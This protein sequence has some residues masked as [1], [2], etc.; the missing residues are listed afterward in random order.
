MIWDDAFNTGIA[1]WTG[2]GMTPTND[3]S[4]S[5]KIGHYLADVTSR[6]HY[7]PFGMQMP[8][9]DNLIAAA[10]YRY[11]FQG[12]EMDNEIKGV[13]NSYA[14]EYRIQ[15]PRLG[16]FLSIDP[17][18]GAYAWNSPY[19]FAENRVID[20]VD[21]EGKEWSQATNLTSGHMGFTIHL[22]VINSSDVSNA[23]IAD[24]LDKST[25][26][27]T[28]ALR[29]A[30]KVT[31][32]EITY[33][34]VK[35]A[36]PTTE[37]VMQFKNKGTVLFD[38]E[39]QDGFTFGR[40][41]NTQNNLMQID[42]AGEDVVNAIAHELGHTGGVVH[43]N[44]GSE[45]TREDYLNEHGEKR[46]RTVAK[47]ETA[48][49]IIDA[50]QDVVT[51]TFNRV[52]LMFNSGSDPLLVPAQLKTFSSNIPFDKK[53][54]FLFKDPVGP[55]AEGTKGPAKGARETKGPHKDRK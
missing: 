1:G 25:P 23:Q 6:Q 18:A 16:R 40:I 8:N 34:F 15:D 29:S 39:S 47:T 9:P 10:G 53:S 5:E 43:P 11:G 28:K 12:Q 19:A 20:G 55:R 14:F 54:Y 35:H 13:G 46:T 7:Y 36:D 31:T 38:G 48:Q 49:E 21:L 37:L 26:Y 33:Q 45:V 52:N 30:S 22:K 27:F 2:V 42:V 3:G 24:W 44:E 17:L 51:K 41:G 50:N 32:G 4:P